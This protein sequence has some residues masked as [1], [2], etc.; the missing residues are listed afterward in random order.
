M[1][2]KCPYRYGV[3][4]LQAIAFST[5]NVGLDMALGTRGEVKQQSSF[6]WSTVGSLPPDE[7]LSYKLLGRERF[8][9]G[10]GVGFSAIG[11]PFSTLTKPVVFLLK[12][13]LIWHFGTRFF[14]PRQRHMRGSTS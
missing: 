11:E 9:M 7:W 4:Y 2:D 14:R 5:P 3:T 1:P 13:V 8:K 10:H 6:S 12:L